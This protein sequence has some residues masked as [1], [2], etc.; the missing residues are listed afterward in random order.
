MDSGD[1]DGFFEG[2]GREDGGEAAGEHG[3]AAAG[4]AGHEEVVGTGGG[5]FEG[6]DGVGLSFDV[7]VIEGGVVGLSRVGGGGRGGV[8]DGAVE[9]FDDLAEVLE[10]VDFDSGGDG[11]FGGVVGGDDESF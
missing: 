8:E 6:A 3:F 5:D 2:K 11:G 4:G 9:E 7:G 1:F 10:S